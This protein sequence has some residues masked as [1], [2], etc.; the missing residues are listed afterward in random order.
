MSKRKSSGARSRQ[1]RKMNKICIAEKSQSNS[2]LSGQTNKEVCENSRQAGSSESVVT[3]AHCDTSISPSGSTVGQGS[4]PQRSGGNAGATPTSNIT[5]A[6]DRNAYNEEAVN[7]RNIFREIKFRTL[8]L[9]KTHELCGSCSPCEYILILYS[10]LWTKTKFLIDVGRFSPDKCSQIREL[11]K[12]FPA[13]AVHRIFNQKVISS[14]EK[15]VVVLCEEETLDPKSKQVKRHASN[16]TV[17]Q[18]KRFKNDGNA[19]NHLAK[20]NNT[21]D[22]VKTASLGAKTSPSL[23]SS[24]STV[25]AAQVNGSSKPVHAKLNITQNQVKTAS[26]GAKTSPSLPS[27]SSTVAAV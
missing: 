16:S 21:Q 22:Q 11:L 9:A 23:P 24:S 6:S 19:R 26:M 14:Q 1:K 17:N 13:P 27:S 12:D 25:A 20:P 8:E 18:N 7:C 15:E 5:T 4:T 2:N 3:V 10:C